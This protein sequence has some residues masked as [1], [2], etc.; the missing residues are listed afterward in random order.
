ML[1]LTPPV[2]NIEPYYK[3]GQTP[4]GLG[5][6]IEGVMVSG[7]SYAYLL[8]GEWITEARVKQMVVDA[9]YGRNPWMTRDV[10]QPARLAS[11]RNGA[12]TFNQ[13]GRAR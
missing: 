8:N 4:N 13:Y 11:K 10:W 12:D 6:A 5:H 2:V 1:D 7:A 3:L 9:Y